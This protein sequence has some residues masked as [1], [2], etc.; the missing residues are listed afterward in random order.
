M[1]QTKGNYQ[2]FI[3]KRKL[4]SRFD[5]LRKEN[6]VKHQLLNPENHTDYLRLNILKS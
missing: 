5:P 4:I 6:I 2:D 1:E 3:Q